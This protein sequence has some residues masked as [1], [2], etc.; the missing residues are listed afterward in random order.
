MMPIMVV[1]A[2]DLDVVAI[3]LVVVVVKITLTF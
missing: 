1:L 2:A 3:Q